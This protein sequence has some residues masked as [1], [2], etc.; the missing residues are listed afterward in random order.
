MPLTGRV[1]DYPYPRDFKSFADVENYCKIL[2]TSLLHDS[3]EEKRSDQQQLKNID[4]D[5]LKNTTLVDPDADRIVFWDDGAG[6]YTWL[7]AN[8]G[9]AISGTNLNLS[10][11]GLEALTAPGVDRIFFWDHSAL[12]SKW[13]APDGTTIEIS[14]TTL[15]VLAGGLDHGGLTGLGD[16]DHSAYILHS[17]AGAANDFLVASG[18]NTYVKKTLV[19]TGEILEGDISHD[20]LVDFT[21]TE[22]FTMLDED[23]MVSNSAAEAATQQSVKAYIDN[24]IHSLIELYLTD[25]ADGDVGAYLVMDDFETGQGESTVVLEDMGTGDDQLI[26]EWVTPLGGLG[27]HTLVTGVYD[28]H[29]HAART[30]GGRTVQ[31]YWELW[32]R[33]SGGAETLRG[34][35]EVTSA[36]TSKESFDPHTVISTDVDI[37]TTDRIVVKLYANV[38]AT[39]ANDTDITIYMEGSVESHLRMPTPFSTI[40]NIFVRKDEFTQDSGVL[41]GTGSGAFQE[42][43][44][45]TLRTSLGLGTGDSPTF[46]DL[47]LSTPSNIY[48]LSHDSFADFASNEHYLQTAI[49][50]ISTA[51][52]TGLLKVTTGTGALSVITDSSANWDSAYSHVS[53]TGASHSYIDQTITTGATPTF[54]SLLLG[55][56]AAYVK[57]NDDTSQ[58]TIYSSNT[59]N[60]GAKLE[61]FSAGAA[62]SKGEIFLDYGDYTAA[63]P[64]A[65]KFSIRLMDNGGVTDMLI[66]DVNGNMQIN[67]GGALHTITEGAVDSGGSGYKV[68]R[69]PN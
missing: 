56:A 5:D 62:S 58:M 6:V 31:L 15:Q 11:L 49:T 14:G 34:R 46:T 51:L 68:L 9:L 23:D 35:S 40:S 50:N 12:A 17:L 52:A 33:T 63:K 2:R 42:E 45:A 65:T 53:A 37:N 64:P 4:L 57:P 61:F 29:F 55:S 60:K 67:I 27:A 25:T 3:M 30:D 1:K 10:H 48:A 38:G 47:T 28:L 18:A 66:F 21:S 22:H 20:N 24:S 16:P 36:V 8:T 39:P 43:T 44:G 69:V 26:E 7:G 59:A 54:N 32:T 13:L 41:V 19:E